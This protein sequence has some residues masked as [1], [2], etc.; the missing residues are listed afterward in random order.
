MAI[1]YQPNPVNGEPSFLDEDRGIFYGRIVGGL[2]WPSENPGAVVVV[3]EGDV[4]RP[5]RPVQVLSEFEENT[6]GDLIKRCSHLARELCVSDFFGKPD[7]TCLRYIDQFNAEARQ[8]RLTQF[9]FK[10]APSYDLPMDYH[11]NL[12]RDRITPGKKTIHFPEASQ[13]KGQLLSVPENQMITEDIH[14][15]LVSALAYAVAALVES[16]SLDRQGV[17]KQTMVDYDILNWN[18]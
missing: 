15:P 4:W 5:P 18:Q 14:Y 12:L 16:E 7:K 2:V 17:Q 10:S 9:Y 1:K 6:I 13:L 8:N 3:G 11:Y